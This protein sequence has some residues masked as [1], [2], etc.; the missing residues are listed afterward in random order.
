MARLLRRGGR[1]GEGSALR[2]VSAE[3]GT[4]RLVTSPGITGARNVIAGIVRAHQEIARH[5]VSISASQV[6][7]LGGRED[8]SEEIIRDERL[9]QAQINVS[10]ISQ[11]GYV[12]REIVT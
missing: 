4:E 12:G 6:D 10:G 11:T 1:N 8:G 3:G 7:V 2:I 5:D 9:V